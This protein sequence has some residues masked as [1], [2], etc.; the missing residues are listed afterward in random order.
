[1]PHILIAGK[2]HPAGLALLDATEGVTY[3]HVEEISEASYQDHLEQADGMVIRTQPMTAASVAKAARQRQ[4]NRPIHIVAGS[5][6]AANLYMRPALA[7][8]QA[9]GVANVPK[10]HSD[11]TIEAAEECPGECIFIEVE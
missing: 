2:L 3:T 4:R 5:R 8:L 6:E 1:M 7:W 10:S 9:D 11:A